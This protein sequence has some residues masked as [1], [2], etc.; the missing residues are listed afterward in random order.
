MNLINYLSYS[1][2]PLSPKVWLFI[3]PSGCYTFIFKLVVDP[4]TGQ[5]CSQQNRE[6]DVLPCPG[7]WLLIAFFDLVHPMHRQ[8]CLYVAIW[9]FENHPLTLHCERPR[10]LLLAVD[11]VSEVFFQLFVL[12]WCPWSVLKFLSLD[13]ALM[14]YECEAPETQFEKERRKSLR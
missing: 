12:T 5:V 11:K 9:L 2:I 10:L 13:L 1:L 6:C 3:L 4:V 7:L 14:S 8:R